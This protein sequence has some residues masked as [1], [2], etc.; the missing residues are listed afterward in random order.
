M[1]QQTIPAPK[2]WENMS[3]I[4]LFTSFKMGT[5]TYERHLF[6]PSP[7]WRNSVG[8]CLISDCARTDDPADGFRSKIVQTD[9]LD[10]L[11]RV[12]QDGDENIQKSSIDTITIFAK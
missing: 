3:C 1:I 8:R 11:V 12:L 2:W 5:R 10:H 7:P 9:A 4:V 6:T